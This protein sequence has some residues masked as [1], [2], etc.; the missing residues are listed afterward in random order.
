MSPF[1]RWYG[2]LGTFEAETQAQVDAG[3][4]DPIDMPILLRCI[5]QWH[6]NSLWGGLRWVPVR[7]Y[8]R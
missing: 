1:E 8:P 7:D 2:S 5:R 6:A 3:V 4:L